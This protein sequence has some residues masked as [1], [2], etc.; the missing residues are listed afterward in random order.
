MQNTIL[1]DMRIKD[2]CHTDFFPARTLESNKRS[3]TR[4]QI[5]TARLSLETGRKEKQ[6][7][8]YLRSVIINGF[9]NRYYLGWL[10]ER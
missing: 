2:T 3:K 1:N 8:V 5:I 9:W 7:G 6:I 4:T 10:L